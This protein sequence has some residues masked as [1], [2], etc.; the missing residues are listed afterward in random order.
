MGNRK[1]LLETMYAA[2]NQKNLEG[3]LAGMH[4]DVEWP[5]FLAG[6]RIRG[7]AA[8]RA[9]WAEQFEIIDPEATPIAYEDLPDGR[10]R[11]QLHYLIRA[12]AGGIWT[13]EIRHNIFT[14]DGDRVSRMEWE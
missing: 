9:Y 4:P 7:V 6:G 11:V 14:F 8:L 3:L 2:F 10:I 12:K 13:D 5:N 1:A